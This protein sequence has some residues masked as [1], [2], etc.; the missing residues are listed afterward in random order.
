MTVEFD[1][2]I[3]LLDREFKRFYRFDVV[4]GT[5]ANRIGKGPAI[6]LKELCCDAS[7]TKCAL[8]LL[9]VGERISL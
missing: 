2:F 9:G 8:S 1:V 3:A 5:G 7:K 4:R 6:W